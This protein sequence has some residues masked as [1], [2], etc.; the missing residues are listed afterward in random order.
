MLL[1]GSSLVRSTQ[2]V[3]RNRWGNRNKVRS[4]ETWRS[5]STFVPVL[6]TSDPIENENA[7]D[8]LGATHLSQNSVW[9]MFRGKSS[10]GYG[11][12]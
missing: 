9:L 6:R 4:T 10:K 11:K 7:T 2:N 5:H 1:L 8:V 3:G 12:S